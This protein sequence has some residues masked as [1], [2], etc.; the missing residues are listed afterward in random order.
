M[1]Y[2]YVTTDENGND[3][4]IASGEYDDGFATPD[5]GETVA[6][7]GADGVERSWKVVRKVPMAYA[8]MTLYVER[9]A[10]E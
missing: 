3:D 7:E 10:P 5:V 4:V 1:K 9:L 8:G 6:L 2:A